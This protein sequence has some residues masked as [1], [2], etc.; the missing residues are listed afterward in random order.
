MAS[1]GTKRTDT[2]GG[3]D[4]KED[5]PRVLRQKSSETRLRCSETRLRCSETEL[6]CSDTEHNHAPFFNEAYDEQSNSAYSGF[7]KS[8][9]P[10]ELPIPNIWGK[11]NN[12]FALYTPI[13]SSPIKQKQ[14]PIKPMPPSPIISLSPIGVS[15]ESPISTPTCIRTLF[16][17]S[18]CE[19]EITKPYVIPHKRNKS[20]TLDESI[21]DTG[22][23]HTNKPKYLTP[24]YDY[25]NSRIIKNQFDIPRYNNNKFIVIKGCVVLKPNEILYNEVVLAFEIVKRYID[26]EKS[27]HFINSIN[28]IISV[29]K[30]KPTKRTVEDILELYYDNCLKYD[31]DEIINK[32]NDLVEQY[33]RIDFMKQQCFCEDHYKVLCNHCAVIGNKN[34]Q[35]NQ[36]IEY[37]SC[38]KLRITAWMRYIITNE[39][40]DQ[41]SIYNIQNIQRFKNNLEDI[42]PGCIIYKNYDADFHDLE[43]MIYVMKLHTDDVVSTG[44]ISDI[45]HTYKE[46]KANPTY[47]CIKTIL[48][49]YYKFDNIEY[50]PESCIKGLVLR[51]KAPYYMYDK[52]NY[53]CRHGIWCDKCHIQGCENKIN[54]QA[55]KLI[56]LNSIMMLKLTSIMKNIIKEN[57]HNK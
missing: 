16:D 30:F 52:C 22:N 13:P 18:C 39:Y 4:A 41:M 10:N 51:Y 20:G 17:D 1:V 32:I 5:S 14:S 46:L 54:I 34:V 26:Q 7:I 49:K 53:P 23:S 24:K 43:L 57:N 44:H 42:F 19:I 28:D 48:S 56:E 21:F 38:L 8:P 2:C 25:L 31:K 15:L 27:E 35:T 36:L 9:Q 45:E 12:N 50:T 33:K 47:D 40:I 37:V 6:G 55:N 11:V 3:G 29:L